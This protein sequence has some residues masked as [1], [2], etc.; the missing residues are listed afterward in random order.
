MH[1]DGRA[2]PTTYGVQVDKQATLADIMA[3]A[4]PLAGLDAATEQ[5]VG[6]SMAGSLLHVN[7]L[8][9]EVK[10]GA[11]SSGLGLGRCCANLR[12]GW[13]GFFVLFFL[14]CCCS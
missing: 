13:A 2:R 12:L 11:W 14:P 10:V 4:A 3:A 1:Y 7:F 9:P 5:F 6:V 8:T